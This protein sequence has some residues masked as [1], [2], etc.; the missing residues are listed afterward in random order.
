VNGDDRARNPTGLGIPGHVIADLESLRHLT[1]PSLF[2][3]YGCARPSIC[4]RDNSNGMCNSTMLP[5]RR[6]G[7]GAWL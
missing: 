7:D 4:R 6:H 2:Q 5:H 3:L 1:P